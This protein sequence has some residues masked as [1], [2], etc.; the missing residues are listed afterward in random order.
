M[1]Y[2]VIV[3]A[4]GIGKRAGQ[5]K[6]KLWMPIGGVPLIQRTLMGLSH[7]L[8]SKIYLII[9]PDEQESFRALSDR[10]QEGG[11]DKEISLIVGG[12][13]RQDSVFQ[14]L[15]RLQAQRP[16]KVWIH[17]GARPFLPAKTLS[18]LDEKTNQMP[19][20]VLAIPMEDTVKMAENHI[21]TKTLNRDKLFRIQTPQLFL[22]DI[23]FESHQMAMNDKFNATDDSLLLE[24]YGYD[25]AIVLGDKRNF[26]LTYPED[27]EY[28][29]WVV[30]RDE[31]RHWL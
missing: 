9:H 16:Q 29:N 1:S 27:F 19:G 28:A 26:K 5:E 30:N 14:G 8:I 12:A 25:V 24:Y 22:Y 15:L 6:N 3:P 7:P 31:N 20:A 11:F 18:L 23:I 17:D 4:A 10:L 21:I 13:Q 2:P